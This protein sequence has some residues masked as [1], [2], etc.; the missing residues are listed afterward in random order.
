MYW[1]SR[2]FR[3]PR[4]VNRSRGLFVGDDLGAAVGV[5]QLQNHDWFQ[6][7]ATPGDRRKSKGDE[8]HERTTTSADA[9]ISQGTAGSGCRAG[10]ARVPSRKAR[11]SGDK[12]TP[13]R[14]SP[15]KRA[16]CKR[17][18]GRADQGANQGPKS[19]GEV[20]SQTERDVRT[21]IARTVITRI[22]AQAC[23]AADM[24]TA[25]LQPTCLSPQ[26]TVDHSSSREQ[27]TCQ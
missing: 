24:K 3:T 15:G 25:A 8:H 22:A 17:R 5:A 1:Q 26:W 10:D 21:V 12:P 20:G 11:R 14:S 19:A 6:S 23:T 2:W 27:G 16:L 13:S 18:S 7:P 4:L 9:R